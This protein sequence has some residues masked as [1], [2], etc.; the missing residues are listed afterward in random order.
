MS[1]LKR[2]TPLRPPGALQALHALARL[3]ALQA[4]AWLPATCVVCG[5]DD[6]AG[7]CAG[8]ERDLP[9][10]GIARCMRCGIGLQPDMAAEAAVEIECEACVAAP[11]AFART[12]VLADYAAPLDRVVHALKFGRDASLARP[13]GRALAQCVEA[14]LAEPRVE[15]TTASANRLDSS[16]HT[17]V[18]AVPLS[19]QRLAERG[20]NQSLEIARAFARQGS[21]ALEH[22]L[23]AR[24][25]GSAPASTMH[26]SER[27][28][29]LR[30]AFDA[31]LRVDRRIVLVVDDVMT[32]GATL[33]AAADALVRAGAA[34]VINCVVARTPAR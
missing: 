16:V 31:P 7:L 17:V 23:L 3:V 27:R 5:C 28:Q 4:D 25:R 24:A 11:P 6:A 32:T 33:E 22:R 2:T 8:C 18:T 9:G 15:A 30:G 29:A 14:V 1:V 21:F 10:A 13:L 12:I 19:T 26:A 20:F 34:A